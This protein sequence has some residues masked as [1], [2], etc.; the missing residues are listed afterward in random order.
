MGEGLLSMDLAAQVDGAHRETGGDPSFRVLPV[1]LLES[2][3]PQG[4]SQLPAILHGVMVLFVRGNK[5]LRPLL[6]AHRGEH[7]HDHG[8]TIH[9]AISSLLPHA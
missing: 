9:V 5:S 6:S 4:A 2:S 7:K 1:G 8:R 3:A